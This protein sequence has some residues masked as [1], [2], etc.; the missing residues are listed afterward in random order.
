VTKIAQT[1]VL[2]D[3]HPNG[4]VLVS[5]P[6][7][8]DPQKFNFARVP[9]DALNGDLDLS[10]ALLDDMAGD[11]PG[12]GVGEAPYDG[13]TYGRTNAAWTKVLPLTGGT[14]TGD[15]SAPNVTA[16]TGM[17]TGIASPDQRIPAFSDGKEHR[18][19]VGLSD[20]GFMTYYDTQSQVAIIPPPAIAMGIAASVRASDR[21]FPGGGAA[22]IAIGAFATSDSADPLAGTTWSY[23]GTNRKVANCPTATIGMELSVGCLG[24]CS[25]FNP[26]QTG[27]ANS[28]FG[29]WL[30]SGSEAYE[31]GETV[32]PASGAIGIVS[33]GSTW[34]NGIVIGATALTPDATTGNTMAMRL[35]TKAEISWTN[36]N[37]FKAR[38]GFIR[39]DATAAGPGILFET[40]SFNV[41]NNAETVN[42]LQV[43]NSGAVN[44]SGTLG[45][46]GAASIGV[47]GTNNALVITPGAAP[48]SN[49]NINR[50]GTGQIVITPP[51]TFSGIPTI[52]TATPGTN[53]TQAASTAFVAAAVAPL[54]PKA[55]PAFSGG[56]T[57]G[58]T[59]ASSAT[60][61]SQH[62][63]LYGTTYGMN[64]QASM[65]NI[66]VGGFVQAT[67]NGAGSV[68]LAGTL[69]ISGAS[70]PTWT[71]GTGVPA[72]TQ[73][74]GSLYSRTSGAVGSTLYVSQGAGTWNPVAGV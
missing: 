18:T 55:S 72:S 43:A 23:Y 42:I 1:P 14:L 39:C 4:H 30:S 32:Y 47:S 26:Y 8:I 36:N 21:L 41:V 45:I 3:I 12:G 65:V 6:S 31:S 58:S 54:A 13:K 48:G 28:A 22:N 49:V 70:G 62:L 51:V 2:A 69:G 53:T 33:N 44:V 57:F 40:N 7:G 10:H 74:K 68:V 34:N 9:V 56:V 67:F 15:L 25:D 16:P 73:P 64:V 50:T 71:S 24:P 20:N 52:L 19:W 11:L 66:V 27:A 61:L 60:D 5:N 46:S 29:L 59:V 17:F 37:A 35:P 63:A 38:T